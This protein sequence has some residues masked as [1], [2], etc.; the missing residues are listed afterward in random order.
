MK[1][2]RR[3]SLLLALMMLL[4]LCG[5]QE[6][7]EPQ[8]DP[9]DYHAAL[10]DRTGKEGMLSVYY[11]HT[12]ESYTDPGAAKDNY[13]HA[14]DSTLLIS[15]DGK[16][17]LIDTSNYNSGDEVTAFLKEMGIQ[18]IDY[19]VCSH[20]HADHVGGFRNVLAE[21]EVKAAYMNGDAKTGVNNQTLRSDLTA[22]GVPITTL[23]EGDSFQFGDK[24]KV[25]VMNPPEDYDFQSE[26]DVVNNGSVLMKLTYDQSTFL[27]AGDFYSAY[28]KEKVEE[29]GDWLD[30]DICKI[31]HHGYPTSSCKEWVNAVSVKAAVAMG[32][33]VPS[34]LVQQRYNA[35]GAVTC[36]TAMDGTV[37]IHTS[38]DGTY[39][40]QTEHL[41]EL[42]G[43]G[44]YAG[45]NGYLEIR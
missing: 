45:V 40:M 32:E 31:N 25:E 10:I 21:F 29:L 12:W 23:W 1:H 15:P 6:K 3:L 43:F 24:V 5:C 37:A 20:P 41:R 13:I 11:I 34:S 35:S 42:D 2:K 26:V 28:E 38:G 16:T 7:K 9:N 8:G 17:M 22:K 19:L 14:G 18:C 36:Y 44:A 30:V 27:F 4:A 39:Q 33:S